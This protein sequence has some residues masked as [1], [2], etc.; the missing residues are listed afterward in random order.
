MLESHLR[1]IHL[2]SNYVRAEDA[3]KM[4]QV[5]TL[6]KQIESFVGLLSIE[7]PVEG[8]RMRI[9]FGLGTDART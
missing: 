8:S 4:V 1:T 6:K 2:K 9:V 3:Q 5:Q 7:E